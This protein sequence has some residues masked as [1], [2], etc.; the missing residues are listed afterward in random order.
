MTLSRVR[1]R[2]LSA[3][4]AVLSFLVVAGPLAQRVEAQSLSISSYTLVA[5]RPVSRTVSEY[6]Y[7]AILTNGG[8]SPFASVVGTMHALLPTTTVVD[9][10][11]QFD[12]VPARGTRA[13]TDTIKVRRPRIIP[14][15]P[16][17]FVWTLSANGAFTIG[18]Y[19]VV[20]E[21]RVNAL[22][23]DFDYRVTLTNRSSTS[24]SG[25]FANVVSASPTTIV[26]DGNVSFGAVGAGGSR[27]GSDTITLRRLRA[28][29]LIPEVL[30]WTIVPSASS[31]N[32]APV[33]R[34]SALTAPVQP[35]TPLIL[36]GR[37]S[38]DPD[39]NPIAGYLW[40]L[41]GRPA[42]SVAVLNS[43]AATAPFTPDVA[44]AYTVRLT[45][46]DGLLT[47]VTS[48]TF[49]TA[50]RAPTAV[51]APLG[52]AY[53]TAALTLNG[54]G[55]SDPDGDPLGFSWSV[56]QRPLGSVAQPQSA[57]SA[58]ASFS[59][60][61]P[62]TYQLL[63]TVSDGSLTNT[64]TATFTTVNSAPVANAGAAQSTRVG[65]TITL[66]GS[67]S[68]DV[69]G[70]PLTFAWTVT[71]RPIAS[72]STLSDATA[73]MPTFRIDAPGTYRFQLVVRDPS[74]AASSP[75]F[76]TA[77]TTNSPP[78]ANAGPDQTVASGTLVTLSAA[79]STDADGDTLTF[80]W[81]FTQRPAGSAAVLANANTVAPSFIA[82]RRGTYIVSLTVTDPAGASTSDTVSVTTGNTLPVA[83]AGP[84]QSVALGATVQLDGSGSTDVDGD[85]LGYAWS[86]T[87]RPQGSAAVVNTPNAASATF[88]ADLP[89]SYT[90][91]LLVTDGQG[92]SN[93][94]T[95]TLTT[96]N[97]RPVANAGP[98]QSVVVGRLVTLDGRAS[99]DADHDPLT[100]AWALNTK[101]AG[102]AAALSSSNV[103]QPTFT[104]DVPGTYV[105]QLI[106]SDGTLISL[107]STVTITTGNTPPVADP[108]TVPARVALGVRV[109]IDG[110]ASRDADGQPLTYAWSLLSRPVGSTAI[111]GTPTASTTFFTP[112]IGG[113]FVVQLIVNDGF[114]DSAPATISVHANHRP[115]ANAGAD[116]TSLVGAVTTLN[117]S[118]STDADLDPLTFAWTLAIPAGSAS[119]LSNALTSTP[120]FV[121][122]VVG[123]YVARLTVNDGFNDSVVDEVIITADRPA[124]GLALT[125]ASQSV[126]TFATSQMTVTTTQPAGAGGLQVTLT[127]SDN[128]VLSVPATVTIPA[129]QTSTAFDVTAGQLAGTTTV[130]ANA[131]SAASAT[132]GV[133]VSLRSMTVT[134]SA[135]TVQVNQVIP[136]TVT[137]AQPAP[138][139]GVS[140]VLTSSNAAA[141][142]VLPASIAIEAGGSVGTF[143][144]RGLA[145]GNASVSGSALGFT[146][147]SAPVAASLTMTLGPTPFEVER[148]STK[149][150]TLSLNAP[151]PTGG[152]NVTLSSDSPGRASVSASVVVPAGSSVAEV[153][154]TGVTEGSTTIRATAVGVQGAA[155]AVT[156]IPPSAATIDSSPASGEG[157]VAVTRE[158]IFRFSRALSNPGL[159]TPATLFAQFG[160]QVLQSR[161]HVS[162]DRKTVTLFY[163][164]TLPASARVR[165]QFQ[166]NGLVDEL[167]IPL[168]GDLDGQPGGIKL[169]DFD[170]LTLTTLPGTAVVGRVFASQLGDGGVN[171]PLA[172][173][174]ISVDGLETTLRTTTDSMGNFR[175]QPAPVGEF[176]V[177]I[178]GRAATNGVPVGAYYPFVGKKWESKAQQTT[179]IPDVFL[180]LIVPGTLQPVSQTQDTVITFPAS[181]LAQDPRLNGVRLNVPADSLYSDSGARGGMV[182]IAPVAPDR[183]PSPLPPGLNL[184]LVITVQTDG[185]TNF[186]R[187]VPVCFPNLPD[188]TTRQTLQPGEKTALWSFNHDLGDWDVVGPMTVSANGTLACSDSGVGIRQPGWHGTMP[189]TQGEGPAL[190]PGLGLGATCVPQL[191]TVAIQSIPSLQTPNL[192]PIFSASNRAGEKIA[193]FTLVLPPA[194]SAAQGLMGAGHQLQNLRTQYVSGGLRCADIKVAARQLKSILQSAMS[195]TNPNVISEL[196]ASMSGI[197]T[198][199][200]EARSVC[201]QVSAAVSGCTPESAQSFCALLGSVIGAL[202]GDAPAALVDLAQKLG[203]LTADAILEVIVKLDAIEAIP[204]PDDVDPQ[205]SELLNEAASRISSKFSLVDERAV[206]A[207]FEVPNQ[208]EE[209]IRNAGQAWKDLWREPRLPPQ[210]APLPVTPI[211]AVPEDRLP[212]YFAVESMRPQPVSTPPEPQA[213]GLELRGTTN[214]NGGYIY[215]LSPRTPYVLRMYRHSNR[216]CGITLGTSIQAGSRF[217]VPGPAMSQC[218]GPD[219]DGDG[220]TDF[221]E[222]A[223]GTDARRVDSDSDG[224]SDS[225]ELDNHTNPLDG[226][227]VTSGIVAAA[228]T[229]GA[230]VDVAA[231]NDIAVVA[232]SASGVSVLN[233][234]AGL[235]AVIV[236]QVDTPGTAQA[237]AFE[238]NLV[239]VADG[240]AGLAIV[241]I[242]D[243]PAA[244]IV[245]QVDPT[246]LGGGATSVVV[247]G[248]IAYVGLDTNKVA[249]IDLATSAVLDVVTLPGFANV[250]DVA[251]ERDTLY[252]LTLGQLHAI[253]LQAPLQVAGSVAY[254]GGQGAGGRRLR[255]FAGGGLAYVTHT[256][257]YNTFS[258]AGS[259]LPTLLATGTTSQFGWKQMVPNGSGLGLAAVGPNSTNDGPHNV[260]LYD[261]SDPT[262]TNRF[263]TEF[264]TPGLA[265]AV[266]IYNGV[267]YVADSQ[268][269]LQV[270]NYLAPDRL[271]VPPTI[272]L[273]SNF[274]LTG[275]TGTAEE[276]K[277]MRLTAN[278]RDDV[279]VRNVDFLVDGSVVARDGNFPFEHRFTTPLL[280]AA[281]SFTVRACA[282]DTGGNRSCTAEAIVSL[283]S[284]AT[285]PRVVRVSPVNAARLQLN[286]TTTLS[287]TFSE[288]VEAASVSAS[289]FQLFAAGP[290]G[291]VG[292]NDDT[293]VLGGVVTLNAQAATAV[294]S[295]P[296]PLGAGNYRA[297]VRG[298]VED[299]SGIAMGS[300]FAWTFS[301]KDVKRWIRDSSGFWDDGA[302]WSD[303]IAPQTGD[304]VV[305]D[306][307]A[308]SVVVTFRFGSL[309]IGSLRSTELL[310]ITGANLTVDGAADPAGGL[311]LTSGGSF[312]SQGDMTLASLNMDASGRLSGT[313]RVTVLGATT[314]TGGTISGKTLVLGSSTQWTGDQSIGLTG[315]AGITNP[316]GGIWTI[317][318]NA[319]ITTSGA[320][321][322]AVANF[323][324]IRK[325]G[326]SSSG[327]NVAFD[328]AGSVEVQGGTLTLVGRAGASSIAGP[329]TAATGTVLSLDDFVLTPTSSL[330]SQGIVR[331]GAV[332]VSGAFNTPQLVAV[333]PGR[334][335]VPA[336]FRSAIG[337]LTS[338]R[339]E[340]GHVDFRSASPVAVNTLVFDGGALDGGAPTVNAGSLVWNRGGLG[341]VVG[342]AGALTVSGVTTFTNT[343][344]FGA[345]VFGEGAR[346]TLGSQTTF[347]DGAQLVMGAGTTMVNPLAGVIEFQ[348]GA[349]ITWNS[350]GGVSTTSFSNNGTLRKLGPGTLT[351]APAVSLEGTGDL[352]VQN[353]NLVLNSGNLSG[354]L[355][356]PAASTVTLGS[357]NFGATSQVNA[358]GTVE[359]AAGSSTLAG[360]FSAGAVRITGSATFTGSVGA[361]GPVELLGP[362]SSPTLVLNTLLPVNIPALTVEQGI[363][364]GTAALI[365]GSLSWS[366][367][368]VEINS[369][370]VSGSTTIPVFNV[371]G[372]FARLF[373][374]STLRFGTTTTF[375]SSTSLALG[376]GASIINPAGGDWELQGESTIGIGFGGGDGVV[377]NAGTIRMS[378][379]PARFLVSGGQFVNTGTMRVRLGGTSAGQFD[380]F[381][382][383]STATLG[384]TLDVTTTGSFVPAAGN[385]FDVLTYPSR[386]GEF[387]SIVGN[388]QTYTPTYGPSALTL[389]VP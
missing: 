149:T 321:V 53:V 89:G 119:T 325:I 352:V 177:H 126:M 309:T 158:T 2:I 318:T 139:G 128:G 384:G 247:A 12:S 347:A 236:S 171:T 202:S 104:A 69:D 225:T 148:A 336:V 138:T 346:I 215:S 337:Q 181:V 300:D 28:V 307:P 64:K 175:L 268:S 179:T 52:Q 324:T 57:T 80:V 198:T 72:Q 256:S 204:C 35:G 222:S 107:P 209:L 192:S 319:N 71:S 308:A 299:L 34:I 359:F 21:R 285:P 296:T 121:P 365:T 176:F 283:V 99:S 377:S 201:E 70:D 86:F 60:D 357:V 62:G 383:G 271:G 49:S 11:V 129:G 327:L 157:A 173:V 55:S 152:L 45:V 259:G 141:V 313:G 68:T 16:S 374:G 17:E 22:Q 303:G 294:M 100:F 230:G 275:T 254:Q 185:A 105:A 199:L 48:L 269:G 187:P 218:D 183:I 91:Q 161:I 37:A 330:T 232:D 237:V 147:S 213:G 361:M 276:G 241:D 166:T 292:T 54:S 284:D 19:A 246:S 341:N 75:S 219:T 217:S 228:D 81:Q 314:F 278:V 170:T 136:G 372:G 95:V 306:R 42:T 41:T 196:G 207:A 30:G 23:S 381:D 358:L 78:V 235:N 343:A 56:T 6:E 122:D 335:Y 167:G 112:D 27:E 378:G 63:L 351:V 214:G 344:A 9:G 40:E 298:T 24:I 120:S 250:Q 155:L 333:S 189:G 46:S 36:D 289:T 26:V 156:V 132:A 102:S 322:G 339:L 280:G 32:R 386:T 388:G 252:V 103:A 77:S 338:L 260:S 243:P 263:L 153:V 233:V 210:L 273:E 98:N 144:V 111:L 266:S 371:N 61:R 154:V 73:V 239:A 200:E 355:T 316:A 387:G 382:F 249:A 184:P 84:D 334:G 221:A 302:N 257:G 125:P 345:A 244:R 288:T 203:D 131:P 205:I 272:S 7:R 340:G 270:L 109:D 290:D 123:S 287:A 4:A 38:S 113:D 379:A 326:T 380:R 143:S 33:A 197:A 331:V 291:Q 329:I 258:L 14:F 180:P 238:N 90:L 127:S 182:G 74:G 134:L 332:D 231:R 135:A 226:L 262:Q 168:D 116:R 88:V 245:R 253:P 255:L 178:D 108:G 212:A 115:V 165:V 188:P 85:P 186:D 174:V 3:L 97:S 58:V 191:A 301:V 124:V 240:P 5:E 370:T 20:A 137:L 354:R 342:F 110:R 304:L 305:I 315:G 140:I 194:R 29:S 76:V 160:G 208:V 369:L 261:V 265:A 373:S 293:P 360:A 328:S 51:I 8:A 281:A 264:E 142:S 118:G 43:T 274:S 145:I 114:V 83:N 92:G 297:I 323:G 59:P 172:G 242:S 151:A 320:L 65:A 31:T 317:D 220:L 39:G 234:S 146:G 248:G 87:S 227:P 367:G 96:L 133:S 47:G 349:Q 229:P 195:T 364:R 130:T 15:T 282:V 79:G 162:P 389:T 206:E 67:G 310:A 193:P 93:A 224:I 211:G 25:A 363:L 163:L 10:D 267:G 385:S 375:A 44:G 216:T 164:Q 348:G 50:N 101:P 223:I 169:I 312:E 279:Q 190:T 251:V 356:A 311:S 18:G 66:D 362:F 13:S 150:A 376:P 106:V 82:D 117:G 295:L 159:I 366:A 94:D 277:V 1:P 286:S 350:G 353:G 368:I